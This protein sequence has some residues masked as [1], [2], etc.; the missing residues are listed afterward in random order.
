MKRSSW[1]VATVCAG[2]LAS[3][4]QLSADSQARLVGS[5]DAYAP[6]ISDVALAIWAAPELGFQE[7]KTT[8]LLQD[9]LRAAGFAIEAGGGRHADRLR[10]ARRDR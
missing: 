9:E 2:S 3:A 10:G 6:H 1:F 4:A 7:T 8:A 5:V